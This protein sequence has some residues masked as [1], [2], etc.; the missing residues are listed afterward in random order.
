MRIARLATSSGVSSLSDAIVLVVLCRGLD[1]TPG[2]AAI[3]GCLV[4]GAINFALNRSWVF[5]AQRGA[6]L[7]QA[8]AY[9]SLVVCG[10][11][12][13]SGLIVG[14]LAGAGIPLLIAKGSALVL[15]LAGWN[16]PIS[17]RLVFARGVT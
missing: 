7:R 1:W 12:I 17:A 15:V 16:Y 3:A 4:G 8:I 11:A 9:A 10:G 5:E 6:V 13:L 2:L 14:A